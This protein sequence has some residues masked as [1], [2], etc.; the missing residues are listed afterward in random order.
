M[1]D[2]P[3]QETP[4][5]SRAPR[6]P[7]ASLPSGA[8]T[9]WRSAHESLSRLAKT[10]ARL[11]WEEGGVLLDARRAAVHLHL[12]FASFA[13]YIERLFGYS[14]RST[15][16]RLRVAEALESLPELKAALR[17][18]A[19]GWSA[20]RELSRVAAPDTERAWLEVARDRTIRQIEE[21]VAGHKPGDEPHDLRDPSLHK[22]TL[23]F[24]VSA[25]TFATFRE[26]MA[27]LRRD[28]GGPLDEDTALLLLAR[29]TLGGPN[30]AGRASYQ[31]ALTTC[32]ACGRGWQQGCGEAIEVPSETIEM[33]RCDAQQL[34]R[35]GSPAPTKTH[36]GADEGETTHVGTRELEMKKQRAR[37][38]VPPAIR[39]E[40]MRRD[41][42]RCVVPGCRHATFVDLHH[43]LLRSEGGNH[44][45]DNLVVLCSAHH[46]AQHRGQLMVE[47][48][49]STGLTFRHADG[50]RYGGGISPQAIAS[51]AEAFRA[52]RGLGFREGEVRSALDRVRTGSHP[53]ASVESVLREALV[54]LTPWRRAA[55]SFRQTFQED[56]AFSP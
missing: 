40:V 2:Y 55:T 30:D 25:E 11:D 14:P 27:K 45:P 4:S 36:V 15:D 18:G 48:R 21:L 44:D 8:P 13:E 12:G 41:C 28:A 26:A 33:A 35:I 49:V 53:D 6:S 20:A 34:V 47:G 9:D 38:D 32:E 19:I 52:L 22:H 50:A 51:H 10:R 56:R 37:Q 39:R 46:R 1:Q 16:E 24:E 17:D 29:Q 31:I 3:P 54:V 23:R 42:G 7:H 43:V 5:P